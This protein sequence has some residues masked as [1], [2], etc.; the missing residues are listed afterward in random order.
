MDAK[1]TRLRLLPDVG[2]TDEERDGIEALPG[3]RLHGKLLHECEFYELHEE[4]LAGRR[5]QAQQGLTHRG[6]QYLHTF[7]QAMMAFGSP[8]PDSQ[9]EASR[10]ATA[11]LPPSVI[12]PDA[13][14]VLDPATLDALILNLCLVR[15]QLKR[16]R[17]M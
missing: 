9:A 14:D 10:P 13:L 11:A 1:Q 7:W 16:T 8:L 6:R 4:W 12:I 5:I 3:L 17:G 15:D 2:V